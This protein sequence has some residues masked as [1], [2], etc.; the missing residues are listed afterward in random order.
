M[1]FFSGSVTV[2]QYSKLSDCDIPNMSTQFNLILTFFAK[3]QSGPFSGIV[4]R[5]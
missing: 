2:N 3:T 1:P 4:T 5:Y